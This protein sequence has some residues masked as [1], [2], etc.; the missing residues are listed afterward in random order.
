M[1]TQ[2]MVTDMLNLQD[3]FNQVVNPQWREAGY[4]WARAVWV[5]CG[6]LMDHFGYK[7]WKAGQADHEQCV[8]E[9]VDI[10]HFVMSHELTLA[11]ADQV[12]KDVTH[13]L[14]FA[15]Q[16]Q[17]ASDWSDEQRRV[18]IDRLAMRAAAFASSPGGSL[19]VEFFELSAAFNLSLEDL[20][21][22]YIAKNALNRFRQQHGY[23]QGSYIKQWNGREDNEV[24]SDVLGQCMRAGQA[25]LMNRVL[26]AL[27]PLYQQARQAAAPR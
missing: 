13:I 21:T 9:L 24:L 11:P 18:C 22:R 7:W 26:D 20:F 15:A 3:S 23:K 8:L 27:E 1:N 25:D 19:L 17:S 5:E 2:A 10:W 16:N 4:H 6:E 12:S 14:E